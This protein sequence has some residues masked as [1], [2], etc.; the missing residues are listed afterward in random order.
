[1]PGA[2]SDRDREFLVSM[3]PGLLNTPEGNRQ[4]LDFT[5]RIAQR[6]VDVERMRQDY[7]RKHGRI[8]ENFIAAVTE[9]GRSNPL[10]SEAA[11]TN[12]ASAPTDGFKI[13]RIE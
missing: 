7:V 11:P 12:G 2:L 3:V 8:D 1:M 10:F 9:F 4:I 6:T 5:R 13:L